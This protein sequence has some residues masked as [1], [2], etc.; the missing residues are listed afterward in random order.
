MIES[1]GNH[2]TSQ[3]RSNARAAVDYEMLA[4][5]NAFTVTTSF[6]Q[7]LVKYVPKMR[8]YKESESVEL[9]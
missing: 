6:S 9:S 8:K 3:T 7:Y 5:E 1:E 2:R 4:E